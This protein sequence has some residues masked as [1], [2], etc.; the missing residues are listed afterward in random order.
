MHEKRLLN[1]SFR[2]RVDISQGSAPYS[3]SSWPPQ[4]IHT[5][6]EILNAIF[7]IEC[8]ARVCVTPLTPPLPALEDRL[9]LFSSSQAGYRGDS[10][11]YSTFGSPSMPEDRK[12][13]V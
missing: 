13:V 12:S 5:V 6:R 11:A 1:R 9:P 10:N 7:Y 2:R 8:V 4:K 3:R